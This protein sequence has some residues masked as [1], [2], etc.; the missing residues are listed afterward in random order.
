L[1]EL[2]FS[3]AILYI[4]LL[5]VVVTIADLGLNNVETVYMSLL[6]N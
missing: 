1:L 6:G 2:A 5:T 4:G 3:R